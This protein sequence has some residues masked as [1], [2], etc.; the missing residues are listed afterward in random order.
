MNSGLPDKVITASLR[1][2]R[3][4]DLWA[5]EQEE[6]REWGRAEVI[7]TNLF[8]HQCLNPF[9]LIVNCSPSILQN[10]PKERANCPTS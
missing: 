4:Q 9:P 7:S 2:R 10:A 1:E 8:P 3:V 6:G 5:E